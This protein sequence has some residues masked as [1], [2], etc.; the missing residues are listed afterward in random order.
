VVRLILAVVLTA[1]AAPDTGWSQ[2]KDAAPH[3]DLRVQ[4]VSLQGLLRFF[5]SYKGGT[6]PEA[7]VIKLIE[8]YGLDFRPTAEDLARLRSASASDDLL[9]ALEAARKPP[10][11]KPAPTDGY[12]SVTC[13]PV[14]C[15]VRLNGDAAGTTSHGLLPWIKRPQGAVT[16]TAAR[17]GYEAAQGPQEIRIQPNEIARVEFVL[18][19]THAALVT[20]GAALF[21]RMLEALG[22]GPE[23]TAFRATGILSLQAAGGQR[24]EWSVAE[25]LQFP[26]MARFEISRLREKYQITRTDSGLVWKKRPKSRDTQ[27][28][29]EEGI[30]LLLDGRLATVLKQLREPGL[31]MVA[32]GLVFGI[33]NPAAVRTEGGAKTYTVTLD[34]RDRPGEIRVESADRDAD[35]RILYSDYVAQA[36][37]AYP[38]T[39]QII[40]SDGASGVEARLEMTPMDPSQNQRSSHKPWFRR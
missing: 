20:E 21:K 5:E 6:V 13:E 15:E 18:K 31:T 32:T 14:D 25:W 23:M 22:E 26:D 39:T 24:A 10:L 12:L 19:P 40:R 1:I 28:E 37:V 16:V 7:I 29:V 3:P 36:G 34:A 4:P 2:E 30:R 35:L 17:D 8:I 33:D 11:P 9:N 38:Q 27:Q